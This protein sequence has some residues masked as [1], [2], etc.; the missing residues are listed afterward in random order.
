MIPTLKPLSMFLIAFLM[1]ITD[2]ILEIIFVLPCNAFPGNEVLR[3]VRETTVVTTVGGK[4]HE[5]KGIVAGAGGYGR[6]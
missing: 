6:R 5:S 4:T 3:C 1:T 2:I